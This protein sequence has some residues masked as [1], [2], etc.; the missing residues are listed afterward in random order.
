MNVSFSHTRHLPKTTCTRIWKK[1]ILHLYLQIKYWVK[2]RNPKSCSLDHFC[3]RTRITNLR[4]N[5]VIR[6]HRRHSLKCAS[7]PLKS[8][9]IPPTDSAWVPPSWLPPNKRLMW[10]LPWLSLIMNWASGGSDTSMC[11]L[12]QKLPCFSAAHNSFSRFNTVR[13]RI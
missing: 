13:G 6:S 4:G 7:S 8:L 9:I 2:W 10:N 3:T 11:P 1:K 5:E 12:N